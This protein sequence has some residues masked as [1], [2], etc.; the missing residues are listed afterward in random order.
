[1][2]AVAA[3]RGN[4]AVTDALAIYT[5]TLRAVRAE[6]LVRRSLVLDGSSLRAGDSVLNLG[7]FRR[8]LVVGAGKAALG[9]ARA[10][11]AI[12]GDH[13]SGGLVV[14][15]HGH[16]GAT[17]KVRVMEAGHPV[18]DEAS[19]A[20]GEALARVA[21]DASETDLVL[22]LISGGASAIA[23]LPRPGVGLDDVRA[24]TDALLRCG[25]GITEVNA[26]RACVSE[27]KCGGL[28][29]LLSPARTVCLV[30]SD[31]LGSPL[32]S[33]GSGPCYVGATAPARAMAV[34]RKYRL[35]QAVPACVADAA[36]EAEARA[37]APSAQDCPVPVHVL[38]GDIRTALDAAASAAR[39]LGYRPLV[40]TGLMQG[41]A[42]EVALTL[43]GA[44]SDLPRLKASEGVD[45]LLFGGET[46]VTV[47]GGGVGGR[48]QEMACAAMQP[49]VG[50]EGVCFLAA[51]T[52]G[53]DGP[54]D[55]AGAVVDDST[56]ARA[57]AQ[58]LSIEGALAVSDTY[59]LLDR[60][61]CLIR[62]GPTGSNVGDVVIALLS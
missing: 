1:M 49:L 22:V 11:E 19:V 21:R 12:L 60:L 45:C 53:T 17:H 31:V 4:R 56:F 37:L 10:V 34:L 48:C 16:G 15:K 8:I 42:R 18:P 13:L 43:A 44:A 39:G 3:Y 51:G 57:Q 2:H 5:A 33:I 58:G 36:L 47:R 28:A 23:E 41:E 30:L 50:A 14:T 61:G 40:V 62:T 59:P 46:T 9:M 25:A 55:A 35:D 27:L 7:D 24:T 32:Q 54:T 26:V 52:D 29:R 38:T 6:A 20:G